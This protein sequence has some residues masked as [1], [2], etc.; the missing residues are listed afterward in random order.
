MQFPYAIHTHIHCARAEATAIAYIFL[1]PCIPYFDFLFKKPV[2]VLLGALIDV[3]K[4]FC[5][6][7]ND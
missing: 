1:G 2:I 3:V 4:S 7:P 6:F 5:T